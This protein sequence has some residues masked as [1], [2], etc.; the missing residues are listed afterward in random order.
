TDVFEDLIAYVPLS[1]NGSVAVRHGTFPEEAAGEEVSGNF[2]S[3]VSAR[4]TL[5]RG[6]TVNDEKEHAPI[7]VLSYNYW[8]RSFA[9]DPNV[10][11]QT[12]YVK[13]VPVT[14]VGVTA[15]GFL[16]VEPGASTDF[17]VPLQNRPE[18]NAWGTPAGNDTLYGSPK[19]CALRMMARLRSGVTPMQAQQGLAGDFL[20]V[21][22]QSLGNVDPTQW[23]PLLDFMPARGIA[24]YNKEYRTP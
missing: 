12:M 24:G 13:G 5:G 21:V 23:K 6:F 3:G 11:G 1:F 7:A 4:L 20:G 14:I 15:P 9:R 8:T 2:F 10:L 19:W 17:W 18:L 16:G 22:Q